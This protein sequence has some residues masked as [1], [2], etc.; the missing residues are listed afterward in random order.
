MEIEEGKRNPTDKNSEGLPGSEI[1]WQNL[2]LV[3]YGWTDKREAAVDREWWRSAGQ[4]YPKLFVAKEPPETT[5]A[6]GDVFDTPSPE[7]EEQRTEELAM[8]D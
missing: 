2:G 8:M 1:V 6:S 3:I 7:Q 4:R 5:V